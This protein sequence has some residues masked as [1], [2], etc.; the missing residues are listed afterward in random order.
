MLWDLHC[1]RGDPAHLQLPDSGDLSY[2]FI[3]RRLA[4]ECY[5]NSIT[6]QVCKIK[7][8]SRGYLKLCVVRI[9]LECSG[10]A[11]RHWLRSGSQ[12]AVE[13]SLVTKGMGCDNRNL[14]D[15]NC[16]MRP[17]DKAPFVV[18]WSGFI[19]CCMLIAAW[20]ML[21][22]Q[23]RRELQQKGCAISAGWAWL[24]T[25]GKEWVHDSHAA[26]AEVIIHW[27]SVWTLG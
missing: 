4:L 13:N 15:T 6:W 7:V 16:T 11:L 26:V 1:V 18:P 19:H 27:A 20:A 3:S 21:M 9:S 22:L 25:H 23:G 24:N 17:P 10:V 2:C 5:C 14:F 8:I 12:R